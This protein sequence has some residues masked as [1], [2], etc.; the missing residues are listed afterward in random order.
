MIE[1]RVEQSGD[2]EIVEKLIEKAFFMEDHSD[3]KEQFLVA[4]L[5]LSEAF[6]A[7]LSLVALKDDRIVGYIMFTRITIGDGK[8]SL[9]LAPV[10]VLPKFQGL[11]IGSSLIKRGH[12]IALELGFDSVVLLGHDGYYPRFGYRRLS[13]FG[14]TMPF[15]ASEECCMALELTDGALSGVSGEVHYA[16]EFFE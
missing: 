4:R 10:A 2:H 7:E 9:A 1:I 15:E 3:H 12:E 16:K 8:E 6:V 11:G 13:E 14:I 5:R